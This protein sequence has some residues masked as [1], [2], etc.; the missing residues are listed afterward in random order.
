MLLF[1]V[2]VCVGC[3][4]LFLC[5]LCPELLVVCYACYC[6]VCVFVCSGCFRLF[7]CRLFAALLGCCFGVCSMFVL[8][9]LFMLLFCVCVLV[10][11]ICFRVACFLCC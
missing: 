11:F 6:F 5:R 3:F 9:V 2:C 8:L 10:A 1:C 4:L 7:L